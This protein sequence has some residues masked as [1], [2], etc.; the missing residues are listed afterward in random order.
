MALAN[1]LDNG[2]TGF[3]GIAVRNPLIPLDAQCVTRNQLIFMNLTHLGSRPAVI[4]R[5]LDALPESG[6]AIRLSVGASVAVQKSASFCRESVMRTS[7]PK[8]H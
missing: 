1:A 4:L 5:A 8:P 7:E 6:R 3:V 2:M